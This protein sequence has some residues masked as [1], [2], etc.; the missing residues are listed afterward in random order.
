MGGV[1]RVII[2]GSGGGVFFRNTN[3][4]HINIILIYIH[5]DF[6]VNR[7]R[8]NLLAPPLPGISEGLTEEEARIGA[9]P[10]F[11]KLD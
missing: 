1:A 2:N 11:C 5:F 7:N 8:T 6:I 9:H 10:L 4:K 3:V